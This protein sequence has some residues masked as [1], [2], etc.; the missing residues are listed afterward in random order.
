MKPLKSG[1]RVSIES[2]GDNYS[3]ALT[4]REGDELAFAIAEAVIGNQPNFGAYVTCLRAL[5]IIYES[6]DGTMTDEE[7]AIGN[8]IM[9]YVVRKDREA[10]ERW[11]NRGNNG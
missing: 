5:A 10:A 9:E 7:M 1:Y 11:A 3:A 2:A 8:S 4:V 6:T